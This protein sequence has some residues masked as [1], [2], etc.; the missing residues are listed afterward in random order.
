MRRH[1]PRLPSHGG[2]GAIT[3]V[4][5]QDICP[6]DL[7]KHVSVGT[8]DNTGYAIAIDTLTTRVLR[9]QRVYP[10]R[11]GCNRFNPASTR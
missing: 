11:F 9:I 8:Y 2:G 1:R 5:I 4:A 7:A 3:N 10:D 6:L